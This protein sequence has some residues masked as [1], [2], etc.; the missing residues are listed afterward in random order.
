MFNED[1]FNISSEYIEYN[2][3][4]P[5][6]DDKTYIEHE[7]FILELIKKRANYSHHFG[8]NNKL[9]TMTFSEFDDDPAA[10]WKIEEILFSGN[11]RR[12]SEDY[13]LYV[14]YFNPVEHKCVLNWDWK[15]YYLKHYNIAN[16]K[17]R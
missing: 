2:K 7:K 8:E 13:S 5:R 12:F 11:M 15:E 4:I 14:M 16:T 17:K 10:Y 3:Q 6:D 9:I 1:L